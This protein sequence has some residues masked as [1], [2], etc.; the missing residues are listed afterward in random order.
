MISLELLNGPFKSLQGG[1]QFQELSQDACKIIFEL[2]FEFSN[3]LTSF[4]FSSI[5]SELAGKM[6]DAF[7]QRANDIYR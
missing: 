3:K 2:N 1:W 4:A 7:S 5:F 6:V